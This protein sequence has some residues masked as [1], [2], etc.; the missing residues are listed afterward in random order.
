MTPLWI[1]GAG[2]VGRA[3]ITTLAGLPYAVTWIDDARARFPDP[4][5]DHAT[6]LV[7]QNPTDAAR[8]AAQDAHHLVLTYSHALDLSLCHQI[9]SQPF[10]SLGLIGSA[11]K[12]TRFLKRLRAL[13]HSEQTLTRLTCP[14]GDPTLG[15]HPQAIAVSVV[16]ALL[17]PQAAAT[18]GATNKGQH[19]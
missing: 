18:S 15:K 4:I 16:H 2:H 5:P 10:A 13:G 12:R 7:A 17:K 6:M 11:T 1:Y 9:L 3:L 8:H 19:A 14:I